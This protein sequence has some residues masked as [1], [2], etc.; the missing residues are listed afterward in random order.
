MEQNVVLHDCQADTCT[1]MLVGIVFDLIE[2]IIYL[3]DRLCGY[4]YAGICYLNNAYAFSMD[5][6]PYKI[7]I[8]VFGGNF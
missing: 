8:R 3:I 7:L 2:P 6:V 5:S 4:S 1:N